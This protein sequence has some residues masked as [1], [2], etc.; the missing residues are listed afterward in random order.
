[1]SALA[2]WFILVLFAWFSYGN[3]NKM[4][5]SKKVPIT[6]ILKLAE[7]EKGKR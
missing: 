2:N 7:H 1:M 5:I 6:T 3:H 4:N